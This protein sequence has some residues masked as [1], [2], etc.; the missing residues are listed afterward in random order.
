MD[1]KHLSFWHEVDVESDV[2]DSFSGYL[3]WSLSVQVNSMFV[4]FALNVNESSLIKLPL[5][6]MYEGPLVKSKSFRD[7]GIPGILVTFAIAE[8]SCQSSLSRLTRSL[9]ARSAEVPWLQIT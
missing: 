7:I 4:Y 9:P 8:L 3:D 1:N 2:S 6:C 5:A